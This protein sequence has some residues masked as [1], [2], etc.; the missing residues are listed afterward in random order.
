IDREYGVARQITDE[1]ARCLKCKSEL[2]E[3]QEERVD[4]MFHRL[5]KTFMGGSF[6]PCVDT[7]LES[8]R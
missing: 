1:I 8:M 4:S 3:E 6:E 5:V 2:G 7:H